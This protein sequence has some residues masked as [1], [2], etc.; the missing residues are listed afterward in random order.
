MIGG[1]VVGS[2]VVDRGDGMVT[3]LCRVSPVHLGGGGG[4]Q[5]VNK[6][7]KAE[8]LRMSFRLWPPRRP[9][10]S[11]QADNNLNGNKNSRGKEANDSEQGKH[12]I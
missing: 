4:R 3:A 5:C 7:K 1:T 9:S 8:V 6:N 2:V 11:T 12:D 10:S